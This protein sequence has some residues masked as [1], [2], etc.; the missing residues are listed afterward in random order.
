MI[1]HEYICAWRRPR[2]ISITV[3]VAES[4]QDRGDEEQLWTFL[5]TGIAR[6]IHSF[7]LQLQSIRDGMGRSGNGFE[8]KRWENSIGNA[9]VAS[10]STPR[11]PRWKTPGLDPAQSLNPHGI[12]FLPQ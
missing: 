5:L 12:C 11:A 2:Q 10:L 9:V 7:K 8:E 4:S 6:G 1:Q 3:G